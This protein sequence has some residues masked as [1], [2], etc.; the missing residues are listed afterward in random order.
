[1]EDR[2]EDG[3]MIG[4]NGVVLKDRKMMSTFFFFVLIV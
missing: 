3:R 4:R 2:R 1:M